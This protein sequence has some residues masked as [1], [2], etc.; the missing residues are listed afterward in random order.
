MVDK[1]S[2]VQALMGGTEYHHKVDLNDAIPKPKGDPIV[3]IR[4]LSTAEAATC[5]RHVWDNLETEG[6]GNDATVRPKG[7]NWGELIKLRWERSCM[8]VAHAMSVDGDDVDWHEVSTMPRMWVE[9]L[10]TTALEISGVMILSDP[11]R[12]AAGQ[13]VGGESLGE[14]DGR[15]G[16]GGGTGDAPVQPGGDTASPDAVRDDPAA[17]NGVHPSRAI[18]RRAAKQGRGSGAAKK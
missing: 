18:R 17:A 11:F 8:V 14:G 5:E 1:R 10:E 3:V 6:E 12:F 16:E 15:T 4:P 9:Q 13:V 7:G 2:R